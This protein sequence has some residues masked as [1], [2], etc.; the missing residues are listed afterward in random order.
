LSEIVKYYKTILRTV[1]VVALS[2]LVVSSVGFAKE[3]EGTVLQPKIYNYGNKEF[4][5]LPVNPGPAKENAVQSVED[6]LKIKTKSQLIDDRTNV[7]NWLTSNYND[8]FGG[9]FTDEEGNNV[10]QITE[11]TPELARQINS[12]SAFPDKIKIQKVTFNEKQLKTAKETISSLAESLEL[13]GVGKN[14]KENK[15]NIYVS[16]ESYQKNKQNILR[17]INEDMVNWIIGSIVFKDQAYL[18]PGEQIERN[19]SGN[20][21]NVFLS[22]NS[23]T[24]GTFDYN[25]ARQEIG[26]EVRLHAT[27]GNGSSYGPVQVVD[28]SF[29]I[30]GGPNDMVLTNNSGSIGGV[31]ENN[32][33]SCRRFLQLLSYGH[34]MIETFIFEVDHI[35]KNDETSYPVDIHFPLG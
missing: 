31:G 33:Q 11:L 19:T 18:Y 6:N 15:V 30:P 3:N 25:G 27:S 22:G 34:I 29:D 4:K 14:S 9:V 21:I 35:Q 20:N 24:I 26:D 5:T 10:I 13:E 7:K 1:S 28:D 12:V 2:V 23:L 8:K 17:Y 16:E 32:I